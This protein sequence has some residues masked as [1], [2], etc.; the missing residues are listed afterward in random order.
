[1]PDKAYKATERELNAT[2]RGLRRLYRQAE[3][4]I[5]NE[6]DYSSLYLAEEEATAQERMRYAKKNGL[7]EATALIAALLILANKKAATAINATL[8]GLYGLNYDYIGASM[9]FSR[10]T[11]RA[12]WQSLVG[13][14]A[15]RAYS[16]EA[17]H[18]FITAEVERALK[19]AISGGKGIRDIAREIQKTVGYSRNRAMTIA[20]TETF[21]VGNYGRFQAME[22]AAS[23]GMDVKKKWVHT[24][25]GAAHRDWHV[26]M[27]SEVQDW[28]KPFSNGLM[29]PHE[30]GAPPEEVINC[31]CMLSADSGT[32][33]NVADSGNGKYNVTDEAIEAVTRPDSQLLNDTQAEA[34]RRAQQDVLRD[35]QNDPVGTE[36]GRTYD[37]GMNPLSRRKG[38]AGR[39]GVS[40]PR[41]SVPYVSVHN[42]A[43]SEPFSFSDIDRFVTNGNHMIMSV[44]GNNGTG[45]LLE[46]LPSMDAVGLFREI[47]RLK[48]IH[49]NETELAY[50][51]LG[52]INK[53]G[54]NINFR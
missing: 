36:A 54:Y 33:D 30:T 24:G 20:R 19:R 49:T 8:V 43:S 44:V 1:M 27:N 47:G 13:R 21:R 11:G 17:S 16:E 7:G 37:M 26:R 42:H 14:Y 29:Y 15:R 32:E 39:Q 22:R 5:R 53:Y 4:D 41:E 40:L 25:A 10:G 2:L 52:V 45:Y 34:L 3:R 35:I 48:N 28:D 38:A 12:S 50:A 51:I 31:H 6:V 9:G 18:P 23:L 46:K